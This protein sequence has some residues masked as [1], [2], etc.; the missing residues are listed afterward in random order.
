MYKL[1]VILKEDEAGEMIAGTR[2]TYNIRDS[3]FI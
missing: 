3:I 2:K 1:K